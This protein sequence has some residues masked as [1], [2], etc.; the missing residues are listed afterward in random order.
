MT[1]WEIMF[2]REYINHT[3][4]YMH[5]VS[6]VFKNHTA[7]CIADRAVELGPYLSHLS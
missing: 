1:E 2:W 5:E 4:W 3:C 6:D 7:R